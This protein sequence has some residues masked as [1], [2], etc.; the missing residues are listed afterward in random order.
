MATLEHHKKIMEQY[1]QIDKY[2]QWLLHSLESS[3]IGES[4][5]DRIK[6]FVRIN[7]WLVKHSD[8]I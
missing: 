1:E 2:Y 5:K 3:N 7:P 6:D 8:M 4:N